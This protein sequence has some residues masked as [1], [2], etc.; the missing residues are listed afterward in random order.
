[1]TRAE[2]SRPGRRRRGSVVPRGRRPRAAV[3]LDRLDEAIL[4]ALQADGRASLRHIAREVGA[5][6]T[7]VSSRVHSLERLGVLQG[8]VPLLSVQRLAAI[9]R[10]PQCTVVRI[11][12]MRSEPEYVG[13]LAHRIAEAPSV[14]YLF[15]LNGS[16]ELMALAST[17]SR[18]ETEAL[19]RTLRRIPGVSRVRPTSILR[20][21]KERPN[22]PVGAAVPAELRSRDVPVPA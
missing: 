1:M 22:H 12:P 16:P 19:L 21:H 11:L 14:C 13:R 7:T 17:G 18:R 5:S 6:V 15:E 10:S 20:V 3:P 2:T 9:G 8:F 4:R